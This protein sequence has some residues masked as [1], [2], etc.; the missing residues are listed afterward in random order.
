MQQYSDQL[1]FMEVMI[2]MFKLGGFIK[3]F[4][5]IKFWW[6]MIVWLKNNPF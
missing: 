3:N 4:G 5:L 6:Q 2:I 1:S